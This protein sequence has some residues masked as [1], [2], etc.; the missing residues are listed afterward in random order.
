MST[1]N[2]KRQLLATGE[3]DNDLHYGPF[4]ESWWYFLNTKNNKINNK[5]ICFPIRINM[6]IRVI[7]SDE[8]FIIRVIVHNTKENNPKPGYVC[9]SDVDSKIYA[10]AS[11]LVNETY[12]KYFKG[13]A[14]FSGPNVLGFDDE[15]MVEQLQV[16]VSFFPFN[17]VTNNIT[18][19]IASIGSSDQEELNFAGSG[20]RSSFHHRYLGNQSLICQSITD[21]EKFQIDIYFQGKLLC[22]HIGST[23]TDVWNRLNILSKLD[24]KELFGLSDPIVIQEIKNY[25]NRPCCSLSDWDNVDKMTL[26]F[27]KCLKKKVVTSNLNW[28]QFFIGWKQLSTNII[29]LTT[30]LAT[31][32]PPDFEITDIMLGAWKRMLRNVGCTNITPYEK[33]ISKVSI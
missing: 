1:L 17:I 10:S 20:Y 18:V 16:D 25:I 15:K 23:P 29:E 26:A 19:F 6:R 30:H 13:G 2:F 21:T 8:E 5:Q 14:R 7:L 11:E 22:T 3:I 28:Y 24:R 31:I 4:A 27:K 12:K 32:Y 9:E 33:N